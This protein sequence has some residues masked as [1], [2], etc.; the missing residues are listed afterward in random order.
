MNNMLCLFT[1]PYMNY[2]KAAPQNRT[3]AVESYIQVDLFNMQQDSIQINAYQ[4]ILP[5]QVGQY[6]EIFKFSILLYF[7]VFTLSKDPPQIGHVK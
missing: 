4:C 6:L 5:P 7:A 2:L 1:A 3:L